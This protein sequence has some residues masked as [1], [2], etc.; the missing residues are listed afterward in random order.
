MLSA[1]PLC[2]ASPDV[3]WHIPK[4][5]EPFDWFWRFNFCLEALRKLYKP[6][7]KR[8]WG[9]NRTT[10]T[11]PSDGHADT[12]KHTNSLL[13]WVS[14]KFACAG[15]TSRIVGFPI[16]GILKID[17]HLQNSGKSYK[18]M[19][20]PERWR[21]SCDPCCK[22]PSPQSLI[23]M[24]DRYTQTNGFDSSVHTS[25]GSAG[26][27][28]RQTH[29]HAHTHTPDWFYYLDRVADAGGKKGEP[30]WQCCIHVQRNSSNYTRIWHPQ[31]H[32][33]LLDVSDVL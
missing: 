7:Q 5:F 9:F 21:T 13:K 20:T 30:L 29:T 12:T 17:A 11:T 2:P 32:T 31:S 23:A 33:M 14:W 8:I 16:Q 22:V 27:T 6:R 24:M 1:N 26:I 28:D 18:S 10:L 15:C 19:K 4:T 25:N 3:V